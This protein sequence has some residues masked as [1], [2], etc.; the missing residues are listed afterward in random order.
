M[1]IL[2]KLTRDEF[3]KEDMMCFDRKARGNG[4]DIDTLVRSL[5]YISEAREITESRDS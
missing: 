2:I 5:A 4:G 3:I 1:N